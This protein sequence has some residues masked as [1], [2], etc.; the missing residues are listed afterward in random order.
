MTRKEEVAEKGR[1]VRAYMSDKGY[2]AVLLGTQANF[3]WYTA[4]GDN[5][6]AMATE[7]GVATLVV[8]PE[9]DYAIT[10]NVEEQRILEEELNDLGIE[11]RSFPWWQADEA[12][13]VLQ[14]LAEGPFA[15]DVPLGGAT[16]VSGEIAPLRYSLLPSEQ[17]RYKYAGEVVGRILGEACREVEPG[18]LEGR[19]A[20][21]LAHKLMSWGLIP[22]VVLVATDHRILKYRHPIPNATKPLERYGMLVVGGRYKGLCVSATRFVRFGK[23]DDELRRKQEAVAHVDATLISH[24][25]P[26]ARIG[27]IFAAAVAAYEEHGFADEWQLHHQGGSTGYAGRD[28]KA[29][30]DSDLMVQSSQ[31]FAWNPSITGTKSEDTIILTDNGPNIISTTPDWPMVSAH[32]G[33]RTWERPDILVR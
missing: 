12:E 29:E 18:H 8:T 26:G 9:T 24:T 22:A 23:I 3:A 5:H 28:Y 32:I 31:A 27:D 14:T 21:L 19:I 17:E 30:P 20:G 1:R 15:G 7:S 25:Q 2:G 13:G 6:V 10:N 4:G 16:D 11:V 33:D